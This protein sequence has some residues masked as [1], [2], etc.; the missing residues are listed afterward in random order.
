MKKPMRNLIAGSM[1]AATLLG[2]GAAATAQASTATTTQ[3]STQTPQPP[4]KAERAKREAQ[5]TAALA[6]ALG[7]S[8][9]KVKAAEQAARAAV[10]AKYGK[11]PAPPTTPPTTKPAEPTDA[12]KAEMKARHD[13]F[14]TTFAEKLGITT[15]QL[16]AG[17]IKVEKA[18]LAAEVKAGRLTQAQADKIIKAIED[19]TA[20]IGGPGGPGRGGPG[21]VPPAA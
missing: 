8:T 14:L 21:P 3:S 1:L 17:M 9:S 2:S 7:L 15:D 10:E 19:G 12:Q 5:R 18:H 13:L 4:S 11:P 20:P 16:K 6:K